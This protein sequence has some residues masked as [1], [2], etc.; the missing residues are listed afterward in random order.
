LGAHLHFRHQTSTSTVSDLLYI[1]CKA[2]FGF[3]RSHYLIISITRDRLISIHA[4]ILL[5]VLSTWTIKDKRMLAFHYQRNI[6][7]YTEHIFLPPEVIVFQKPSGNRIYYKIKKYH[8][9]AKKVRLCPSS[10]ALWRAV[11]AC[12]PRYP[13]LTSN[14]SCVL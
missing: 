14:N 13:V 8:R 12:N 1:K 11:P 3:L 5:V 10:R 2:N 9:S 6:V 4:G 7:K